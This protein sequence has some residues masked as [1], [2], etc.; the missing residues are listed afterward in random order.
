M[1]RKKLFFENLIV[2]GLG[3][4]IGKI[5]PF[6]MLP[7]ITLL[8]PDETYFGINDLYN[9]V[10]SLF[11]VVGIWGMT[12]TAYRF[13]FDK[14]DIEYKK[15]VCVTTFLISIFFTAISVLILIIFRDALTTSIYGSK[16]YSFL[17][18]FNVVAIW[19]GNI[20][21]FFSLPTRMQN[22]REVFLLVNS[23]IP[24]LSYGIAVFL[25]YQ[26]WYV[27]ALPLASIISGV[28]SIIIFFILN[29]AWFTPRSFNKGLIHELVKYGL[30]LM[31]QHL[32]YYI[33]NTS[34]KWMIAFYLGQNYNGLYALGGKLGQVSQLVYVA[35]AGGW[36][37]Y[38]YATMNAE[39]QV[40]NISIIFEVLGTISFS[41]LIVCCIGA[42]W[43]INCAFVDAYAESFV[44][45]PYLFFAPL[46]QMLFQIVVGQFT[47]MKKTGYTLLFLVL[48]VVF[49]VCLNAV[50]IPIIGIEGAAIATIIGYIVPL[51]I[52]TIVCC[53][54][55]KII[56][57][58]K[59][60]IN[61][62]VALYFMLIWRIDTSNYILHIVL[63]GLCIV[64]M[65]Y[66]YKRE[67]LRVFKHKGK[68]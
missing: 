43:I 52:G 40:K 59:F 49:N 1:N 23:I 48:G 60:Y 19:V 7:V 27:S 50:L 3:A 56:I 10:T 25:I 2:Y 22:R 21:S 13:F 6:L 4:A 8:L 20:S 36:V 29:K 45:I 66:Q 58:K 42:R 53:R 39:D 61:A 65:F 11:Q 14:E 46:M 35:F 67:V 34:D 9:S 12:D 54:K 57:N 18:L 55:K 33:M 26:G 30:P 15:S 28:V 41:A 31:P 5:I 37:Y 17:V 32:I 63:G 51:I 16:Q 68:K 62:L 47:I 24:L 38:S 64:F 44:V